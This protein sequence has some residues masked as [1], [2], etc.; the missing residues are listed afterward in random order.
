MRKLKKTSVLA[1]TLLP[2]LAA[3][4]AEA[5]G[6]DPGTKTA[7]IVDPLNDTANVYS[8]V[9][10]LLFDRG[11]SAS[12]CTGTLVS[13]GWVLTANHCIYANSTTF[14]H[15]TNN[16]ATDVQIGFAYDSS[17]IGALPSSQRAHATARLKPYFL[18]NSNYEN[19]FSTV[20]ESSTD[21]ALVRLDSNIPYASIHPMRPAGV[22]NSRA[23]PE[24]GSWMAPNLIV[25]YGKRDADDE[26]ATP[27]RGYQFVD[28]MSY[29]AD[30]DEARWDDHVGFNSY[31]GTLPGDSGGPLL[32]ATND[33]W[34]LR[35]CG[36]ASSYYNIAADAAMYHGATEA[37]ANRQFLGQH[38]WD[39]NKKIWKGEECSGAPD[40]LPLPVDDVDGDG[41]P[42]SCD[43]C[44]TVYNPD[45]WDIDR[46][47]IGDVCDNCLS[48]PNRDQSDANIEAETYNNGGSS[49]FAIVGDRTAMTRRAPGDAC[50]PNPVALVDSDREFNALSRNKATDNPNASPRLRACN[51]TIYGLCGESAEGQCPVNVGNAVT[52]VSSVTQGYQNDLWK[53][54]TGDAVVPAAQVLGNTRT[55]RCVCAPE[56][57]ASQC[58]TQGC[59]YLK[60]SN[61]PGEQWQPM[62]LAY[63]ETP[64]TAPLSPT[65][66]AGSETFLETR[67]GAVGSPALGSRRGVPE[68]KRLEW[69]YWNDILLPAVSSAPAE[70]FHGIAWTWVKNFNTARPARTA[71]P[72]GTELLQRLRTSV[73]RLDVSE[74]PIGTRTYT[75]LAPGKKFP[76][77]RPA[78]CPT[79]GV[80]EWIKVFDDDRVDRFRPGFGYSSA[81]DLLPAEAIKLINKFPTLRTVVASDAR[82]LAPEARSVVFYDA[83]NQ[84]VIG[85]LFASGDVYKADASLEPTEDVVGDVTAVPVVSG[86]RQ[87]LRVFRPGSAVFIQYLESGDR[88]ELKLLNGVQLVKPLAATFRAEDEGYYVL[89]DAGGGKLRL[90]RFDVALT[91]TLLAEWT[92]VPTNRTFT[93]STTADGDLLLQRATPDGARAWR[94]EPDAS[95]VWQVTASAQSTGSAIGT[96]ARATATGT[97]V[98]M[99]ADERRPTEVPLTTQTAANLTSLQGAL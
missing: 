22:G 3:A 95:D 27:R 96:T 62:D 47:E 82:W 71:D 13:S 16:L 83:G 9:G 48:V 93:L 76:I 8:A 14:N 97:V 6:A 73:V 67:H 46:D 38:L 53:A 28:R 43:N 50:E 88:D 60:K 17:D 40:S 30:G 5:T 78:A 45:Q 10:R 54:E 24:G 37:L 55:A 77:P 66:V 92:N 1:C 35:V 81:A 29:E 51:V 2:F 69:R 41:I 80:G 31:I 59:E 98:F 18:R 99:P 49:A 42:N 91:G 94:L 89:D 90:W 56:Y 84:K 70:V 68:T 63:R 4:C 85:S 34:P 23:C 87:E 44:K 25:G 36:V 11:T 75:C 52:T 20:N 64:T 33:P 72:T 21:M 39:S 12:T 79:C 7:A 74:R 58:R 26:D 15:A 32:S 65:T 19:S 61:T 86:K 57:S